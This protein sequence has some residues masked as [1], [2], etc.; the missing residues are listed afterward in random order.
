MG[1][2]A[3]IIGFGPLTPEILQ[4]DGLDY[5]QDAYADTV[6]GT[7]ITS[8]FFRC[9]NGSQSHDLAEALC[10]EGTHDFNTHH[11]K[12]ENIDKFNWQT[13]FDISSNEKPDD[14]AHNEIGCFSACL[15]A[16][17]FFLYR[18]NY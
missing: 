10:V 17:W 12:A 18:P 11:I 8:T 5:D 13:L 2:E 15:K 14:D 4:W 16:G 7:I 1:M 9:V 6:E 3:D